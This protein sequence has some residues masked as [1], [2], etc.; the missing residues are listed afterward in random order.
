MYEE[1]KKQLAELEDKFKPLEEEYL[2]IIEE[3]RTLERIRRMEEESLNKKIK[4]AVVIQSYWRG[5]KLRK[6]LFKKAKKGK[7]GKKGKN[8]Q[9]V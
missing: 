3:R 5:F 8:N 9:S 7:K 1:E 4:A 2:K 6:G